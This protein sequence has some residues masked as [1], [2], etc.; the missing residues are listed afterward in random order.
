M[1]FPPNTQKFN[2]TLKE[3]KRK[4]EKNVEK[5]YKSKKFIIID[6]NT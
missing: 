5:K 1:V 2:K 4:K 6:K 3:K